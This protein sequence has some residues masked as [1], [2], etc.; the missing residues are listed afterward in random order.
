MTTETMTIRSAEDVLRARRRATELAAELGFDVAGQ[1]RVATAVSEIARNVVQHAGAP[2]ELRL[3]VAR[4]GDRVGL[5]VFVEDGGVG[6][7]GDAAQENGSSVTAGGAGLPGSRRLMDEFV[8][9]GSPGR[10]TQV[11]MVSWRPGNAA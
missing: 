2:G 8:V 6:L 9:E 3:E 11:R 5:R 4:D 7:P 10:G 1:R